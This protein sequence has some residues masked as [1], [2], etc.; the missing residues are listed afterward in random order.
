[1][2]QDV[3]VI[4]EKP[5][6]NQAEAGTLTATIE[7]IYQDKRRGFIHMYKQYVSE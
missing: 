1:L 7:Y 2:T 3:A 6:A 5:R 4:E